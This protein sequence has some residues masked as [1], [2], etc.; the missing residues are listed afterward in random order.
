MHADDVAYIL[1]T[2]GSTGQPKGCVLTH[3]NLAAAIDNLQGALESAV[4]ASDAGAPFRLLARSAEAFDVHLCECFIA[5]KSGATIVTMPRAVLLQD[6]GKVIA[7]GRVT[8][9]CVVPSLFYTEGRRIAPAD[10]P[11]LRALTIGGEKLPEDVVHTWGAQTRVPMLNAYGPTEAT[12]GISAARVRATTLPSCI[13]AAFPGNQF[14]VLVGAGQQRRLALRGEAGELCI[15]GSHVGRGYVKREE[16]QRAAFFTWRGRPAYATGDMARLGASDEAEYLGRMG[17]S[18]V[19]VRG[20]RVELDEVDAAVRRQW[21]QLATGGAATL[22]TATLLLTHPQHADARLVTFTAHA[23]HVPKDDTPPRLAEHDE[24]ARAHDEL[25]AALRESLSSYMVPSVLVPL[26]FLPLARVSAKVDARAL[27][28]L[29]AAQPLETLVRAAP[30]AA[31]STP[32]EHAVLAAVQHVLR[33]PVDIGVEA[34]L[35][36]FGLESLAAVRLSL[37][38]I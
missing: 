14:V 30:D 37:I 27:A 22:H 31:P 9:A 5:L 26:T 4:P 7:T 36:G 24:V 21:K 15:V 13:G 28:Q 2:S 6:L 38:H 25:H 11:T 17:T 10:V 3:G 34:D 1:Y 12:I 8:H 23:A 35:F 16:A 19:K 29:Y 18:Q 33:P 32:Q 20:A